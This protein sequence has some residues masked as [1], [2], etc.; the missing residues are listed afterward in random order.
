MTGLLFAMFPKFKWFLRYNNLKTRKTENS[1]LKLW[2]SGLETELDYCR[3][4]R[5]VSFHKTALNSIFLLLYFISY[6]FLYFFPL[7][8]VQVCKYFA[9]IAPLQWN[10]FRRKKDRS[11]I[12]SP[13]QNITL[14]KTQKHCNYL[15]I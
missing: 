9:E 11:K 7:F 6:F 2:M 8:I 14:K 10:I 13:K 1:I 3:C 5:K 4:D 15:D 12:V